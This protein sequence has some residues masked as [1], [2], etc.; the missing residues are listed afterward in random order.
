MPM[1]SSVSGEHDTAAPARREQSELVG[2]QGV[3]VDVHLVG[4]EQPLGGELAHARGDPRTPDAAGVG[5]DECVRVARRRAISAPR[6][7]PRDEPGLGERHA[8]ADPTASR[9]VLARCA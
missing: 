3:A 9:N 2:I 5:G 4:P 7:A 6:V 8:E 1:L